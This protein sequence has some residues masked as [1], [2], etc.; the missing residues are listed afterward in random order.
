MANDNEAG[1]EVMLRVF[2]GRPNPVWSMAAGQTE[3]LRRMLRA[4]EES[5]RNEAAEQP[6]LGYQG[7]VLTNR[8]RVPDLP[9]RVHVFGGT[10]AVADRPAEGEG[11][12]PDIRYYADSQ[13]I[14]TWLL[15][16]AAERGYAE[17]IVAMGGPRG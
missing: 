7:F 9:Y 13:G 2:S 5:P 6:I 1:I 16:D 4:S 10:L 15:A 3:Q 11:K 12:S 8:Q 17:A 14:E